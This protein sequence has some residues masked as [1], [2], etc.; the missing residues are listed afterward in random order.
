MCTT[1]TTAVVKNIANW[2]RTGSRPDQFKHTDFDSVIRYH[3][4]TFINFYAEWC[5]HC[6]RFAP[7]WIE[8]EDRADQIRFTDA[9]GYEVVVKLLRINCVQFEGVCN[10]A[11]IR[12]FPTVRM[13]KKDGTFSGYNGERRVENIIDSVFDFTQTQHP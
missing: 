11:G 12:G 7:I 9:N 10:A 2:T 13:Y 8:A 4:F 3:D 5:I 1:V 6:R